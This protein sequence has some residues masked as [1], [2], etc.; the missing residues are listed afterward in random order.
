MEF[1]MKY[2]IISIVFAIVIFVTINGKKCPTPSKLTT[3]KPKSPNWQK[4]ERPLYFAE[5]IVKNAMDLYYSK[6]KIYFKLVYII[7]EKTRFINRLYKYRVKFY[8][9]RCTLNK[10]KYKK[11]KKYQITIA[12]CVRT[13]TP[14]QTILI[15]NKRERKLRLEVTNLENPKKTL[16]KIYKR[17]ANVINKPIEALLKMIRKNLTSNE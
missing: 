17:P 6:T 15:I 10:Q 3:T 1:K 14:F 7:E 9:T 4:W 11:G 13:Y 5:E 16:K 12:R 8:A 2:L